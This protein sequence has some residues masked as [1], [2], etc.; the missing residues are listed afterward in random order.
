MNIS[1]RVCENFANCEAKMQ[2]TT[3]SM[4]SSVC[5]R[6]AQ[7]ITPRQLLP[8]VRLGRILAVVADD[9]GFE[10]PASPAGQM[11]CG[12]QACRSWG[13]LDHR[14][15]IEDT[16]GVL[17][18]AISNLACACCVNVRGKAVA[19]TGG[20]HCRERLHGE[21][22]AVSKRMWSRANWSVNLLHVKPPTRKL[23]WGRGAE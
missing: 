6:S 20:H 15:R 17:M 5:S 13:D 9:L 12:L 7:A 8:K 23:E 3:Q 11:H 22:F 10:I 1:M 19:W 2:Q 18:S 4:L 16:R 14:F 21:C